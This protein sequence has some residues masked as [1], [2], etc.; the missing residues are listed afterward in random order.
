MD[1]GR[2]NF[3]RLQLLEPGVVSVFLLVILLYFTHGRQ[4]DFHTYH[5]A[6]VAPITLRRALVRTVS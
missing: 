5:G 6:W 3:V 1:S 2:W 4:Y